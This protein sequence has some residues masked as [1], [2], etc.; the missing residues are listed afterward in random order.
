MD[1]AGKISNAR[2]FLKED[3]WRIRIKELHGS[4]RFLIRHLR[5]LLVAGKGFIS[6][7]CTLW[8]M[9]LTYFSLLSIVPVFALAFAV[10]K[11]FGLQQHLEELIIELFVGQEDVT[12]RLLTY[13]RNLLEDASGGVIAGVGVVFLIWWV[14]RILET[15]ELSFNNIWGINHARTLGRKFSDYLSLML[16]GPVLLIV[17]S[18]SMV[19]FATQIHKVLERLGILGVFS[20]LITIAVYLVPY[21]LIW[22]LFTFMF[23]F[24]PNTKVKLS[25]AITGGITAGTTFVITQWVYLNFQ[26][27]VA[28]YNAIYGSLA[29][30]PLFLIW[31]NLSWLIV[32]FGAE[33][34]KAHQNEEDYVFE[35]ETRRI[36]HSFRQ[37][38]SLQIMHSLIMNFKKGG[39]PLTAD[40]LSESLEI[41]HR[42]VL[43][44]LQTLSDCGLTIAIPHGNG[45]G[46]AY[47]PSRD[48]DAFTISYVIDA[49][50]TAGIDS[51]PVAKTESLE[52]ISKSLKTF[53]SLM[54]KSDANVCLEDIR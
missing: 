52:R 49:L 46:T 53:K 40:G 1:T 45:A 7:N 3:I 14:F 30:L 13:S 27:G 21:I 39:K 33:L 16:I 28:S 35:P 24:V 6:D 47:H 44:I 48:I 34:T 22:F 12:A 4:R 29:A 8:A 32:L 41:P 5:M 54:E 26:I 9:S 20:P 51:I 36:S 10:A 25:S 11:G 38:L 37:L 19:L 18:S 15:T 23:M 50:E 2:Q 17:S 31:L 42:T 43:E